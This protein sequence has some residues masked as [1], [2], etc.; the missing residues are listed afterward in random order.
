MMIARGLL[1]IELV[2]IFMAETVNERSK[3]SEGLLE[4]C[5][6]A[7]QVFRGKAAICGAR[8]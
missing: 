4:D 1:L 6:G 3:L 7:W 5:E 8:H 2:V